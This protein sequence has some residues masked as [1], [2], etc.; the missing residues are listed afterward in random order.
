MAH[1]IGDIAVLPRA[2]KKV[3]R[4]SCSTETKKQPCQKIYD[5]EC[6]QRRIINASKIKQ[7]LKADTFE[8]ENRIKQS[9]DTKSNNNLV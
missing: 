1:I 8:R 5:S 9:V 4:L 2:S 6:I 7:Q 3:Q